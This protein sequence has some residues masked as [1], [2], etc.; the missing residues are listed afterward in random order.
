MVAEGKDV[1]YATLIQFMSQLSLGN[2]APINVATRPAVPPRIAA[3][4]LK[5]MNILETHFPGLQPNEAAQQQNQIAGALGLTATQQQNQYDKQK[6]AREAKAKSTV[7]GWLGD[8]FVDDFGESG[9]LSSIQSTMSS[10]L[11]QR[12]TLLSAVSLSS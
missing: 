6:I 9:K 7:A 3:L 11:S 5:Y 12:R 8:M 4:A 10:A 1:A 2:P